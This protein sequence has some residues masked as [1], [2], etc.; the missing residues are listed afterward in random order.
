MYSRPKG[1]HRFSTLL[2]KAREAAGDGPLLIAGD[3]NAPHAA[4]GYG[5]ETPKGRRLWE[6]AQNEG[7]ELVAD[8]SAPTR[9]GNSVCADTSPDHTFTKNIAAA[10]WDN[11]QEDW[12]AI[13]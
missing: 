9:R 10:R 1:K 3:F 4:W 6:D 5:H 8:P 13:T 11:T 2:R 7:L 12:E